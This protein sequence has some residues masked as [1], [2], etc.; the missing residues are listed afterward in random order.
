MDNIVNLICAAVLAGV[1]LLYG[2]LGE[3]LTEKSGNLNL[4]VEGMMYMGAIAGMAG[5]YF[6]ELWFGEI[7]STWLCLLLAILCAFLCGM[8]GALIYG[9]LTITLRANQNVTGLALTIFG[10]GFGN[11]FGDV[12]S[13]S[14]ASGFMALS[15]S[16]KTA[17]NTGI[18]SF[19]EPWAESNVVFSYIYKLFFSYNT[20]VY[21]GIVLAVILAFFFNKT[22]VGLNLRAVGEDPATAD[23]AGINVNR[24]KYLATVLGGGICGLGGM[25]ISMVTCNGVWIYDCVSG[26]GW[27]AVAL[28]IFATWSPLRALIGSL[29]F[30]GLSIMRLY[31]PLG[32][33]M[34]IYD[35]F[36]Y[37]ATVLVLVFTS[38]RQSREHAMPRHCGMNY[39]REER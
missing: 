35:I 24:Y 31:V 1:P 14:N 5:V 15:S 4:G 28:V 34:Q 2:T 36:P 10:V 38:I 30:G 6:P 16:A 13:R 7:Q 11:F 3:I 25:Y 23:A 9:F 37:L 8:L 17:F 29:V 32:I 26:K 19:M 22:R 27:I 33:P 18:F 20:L 21:L 12:I 39:F